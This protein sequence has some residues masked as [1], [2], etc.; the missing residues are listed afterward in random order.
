MRDT[1]RGLK[2]VP[3][4]NELVKKVNDPV[5]KK[6]PDRRATFMEKNAHI[7]QIYEVKDLWKR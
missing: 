1:Y 5:I 3:T 7:Y 6:Y 4:F 2:R